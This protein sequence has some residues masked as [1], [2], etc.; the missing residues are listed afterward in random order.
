M[1]K[2]AVILSLVAGIAYGTDF[3]TAHDIVM[4]G[5]TS[6]DAG[7]TN[8]IETTYRVVGVAKGAIIYSSG[9]LTTSTV[10]SVLSSTARTMATIA[11]NNTVV[12]SNITHNL[13]GETIRFTIIN[14]ATNAVSV[15]PAILY[16]K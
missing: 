2:L 5:S 6:I 13:Y 10:S 9:G 1:R 12:N 14:Y 7:Q 16:E 4:F 11:A 3:G 15:V 8:T